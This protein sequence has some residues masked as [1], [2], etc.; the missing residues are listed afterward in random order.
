LFVSSDRNQELLLI[1]IQETPQA[2]S[3]LGCQGNIFWN[4]IFDLISSQLFLLVADKSEGKGCIPDGGDFDLVVSQEGIVGD[5]AGV[6]GRDVLVLGG[7]GGRVGL[8]KVGAV[9]VGGNEL[10]LHFSVVHIY[11]ELGDGLSEYSQPLDFS[12]V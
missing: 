12:F 3:L 2:L 5:G 4:S 1:V 11:L 10:H 7:R 6:I 9:L 8:G